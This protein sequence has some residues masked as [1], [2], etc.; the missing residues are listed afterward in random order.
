MSG[1]GDLDLTGEWT[2][3]FNYPV[4]APPVN[5]EAVLREVDGQVTGTSTEVGDTPRSRGR[6]LHAVLDGQRDGASVR[7]LKMYED[8]DEEY[9]VVRYSGSLDAGGDEISGRWEIG[10]IWSG[11]FLMVRKRG[12]A[13]QVE[14][15]V[16]E[17]VPIR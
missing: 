13:E 7:F 8:A 9:D 12:A 15:K 4:P 17:S 14:R 3:F 6:I 16:E 1:K 11:T 2:G 5:F 10:G